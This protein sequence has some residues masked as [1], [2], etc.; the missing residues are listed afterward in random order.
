MGN[1]ASAVSKTVMNHRAGAV[2]N[3]VLAFPRLGVIAGR[4]IKIGKR[5]RSAT[6]AVELCF[7]NG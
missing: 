4:A 5:D 6:S 1:P 2:V 3:D 7:S